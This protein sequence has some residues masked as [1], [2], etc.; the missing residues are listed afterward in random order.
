MLDVVTD[1]RVYRKDEM[2]S[3]IKASKPIT[4]E[5]PAHVKES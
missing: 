4:P 2:T 3:L 5:L 1:R